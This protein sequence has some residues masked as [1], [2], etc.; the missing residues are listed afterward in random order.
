MKRKRQDGDEIKEKKHKI[1]SVIKFV[2]ISATHWFFT[3][4]SRFSGTKSY[5]LGPLG[6]FSFYCK[7]VNHGT[8]LLRWI[9]FLEINTEGTEMHLFLQV[10]YAYIGF[11]CNVQIWLILF[12]FCTKGVAKSIN[13]E[14]CTS[15]STFH[16]CYVSKY[17]AGFCS[18]CNFFHH[19]S[20]PMR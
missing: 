3:M 1:K 17:L 16:N 20:Y 7:N 8:H 10:K 4:T 11:A 14:K 2:R 6:L 12:P 5:K 9:K 19:H 18:V 13:V 15:A